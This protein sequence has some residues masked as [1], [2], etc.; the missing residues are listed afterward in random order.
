MD[1]RF[2][3]GVAAFFL[4]FLVTAIGLVVWLVR[5]EGKVNVNATA[6]ARVETTG[7]K[8]S[9]DLSQ[10]RANELVHFNQRLAAEVDRS[11]ERRFQTIESQLS[12][13][14]RKLDHLAEKE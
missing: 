8:T 4:T 1:P 5:L 7:N 9:D 12:E 13:I 3:L 11:N 2:L 6:I 14:N 10:H